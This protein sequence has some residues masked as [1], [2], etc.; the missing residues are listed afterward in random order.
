MSPADPAGLAQAT[1]RQAE[2][3]FRGWVTRFMGPKWQE[4]TA[5]EN[6]PGS[7]RTRAGGVRPRLRGSGRGQAPQPAAA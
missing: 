7:W 5:H 2:I 6:E 3:T 1:F 4:L